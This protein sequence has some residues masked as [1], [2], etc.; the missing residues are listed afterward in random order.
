MEGAW[1]TIQEHPR[2]RVTI[3]LF[4]MGLVFFNTDVKEKEHYTIIQSKFKPWIMGF[5]K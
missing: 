2:V 3:D 1:R 5:F 4:F